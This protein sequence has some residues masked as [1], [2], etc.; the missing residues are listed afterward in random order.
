MI[1]VAAWGIYA[2]RGIVMR[3]LPPDPYRSPT[4]PYIAV[5]TGHAGWAELSKRRL[6]DWEEMVIQYWE[7]GP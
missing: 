3:W 1:V 6:R 4:P 7:T 2:L 5:N